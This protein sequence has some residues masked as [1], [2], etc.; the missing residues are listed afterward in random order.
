MIP[1]DFTVSKHIVLLAYIWTKQV[2]VVVVV[3]AADGRSS[4]CINSCSTS[5]ELP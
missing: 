1:T 3:A 2:F 5:Y 4:D